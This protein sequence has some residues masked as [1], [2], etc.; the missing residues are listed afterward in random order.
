M[1]FEADKLRAELKQ[2]THLR[3]LT[4]DARTLEA[5]DEL[6]KEAEERLRQLESATEW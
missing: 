1:G 3:A 5:L 4:N 6:I 2:Y